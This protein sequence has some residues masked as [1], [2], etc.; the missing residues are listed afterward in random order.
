MSELGSVAVSDEDG[1]TRPLPEAVPATAIS[2]RRSVLTLVAVA[3]VIIGLDA[4]TK[5]WATNTLEGADPMRLLGGLVYF[6]FTR[7]SGA[8]WS[9]GSNYTFVFPFIAFAVAAW[10]GWTARKLRSLPWAIALGLVL[11]GA[12]GNLV[13]RV[14]RYPGGI[15][16]HV[17]DFISLFGPYGE[18]F[19]IF[20]IADMALSFGVCLAILLE[21]TGRQRDGTRL[22]R[23][24]KDDA[25]KAQREETR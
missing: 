8:A 12:L 22:R 23:E 2:V 6:S 1:E 24:S 9:M 19:P 18:R 14:F 20:N 16:G 3:V 17:V 5:E 13:D 25:G 11:G 4:A 7:N 15:S 10:I 21:F